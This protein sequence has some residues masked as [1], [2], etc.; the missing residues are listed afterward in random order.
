MTMPT[1]PMPSIPIADL[2][3][4]TLPI[5]RAVDVFRKRADRLRRERLEPIGAAV[6]EANAE[7][8]AGLFELLDPVEAGADR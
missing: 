2:Q 8:L 1:R 3:K 7:A 5:R 6:E 4:Y